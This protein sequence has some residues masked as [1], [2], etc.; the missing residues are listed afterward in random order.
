[1]TKPGPNTQKDERWIDAL[2]R[3]QGGRV[4]SFVC[5]MVGNR[6]VAED[7]TQETFLRAFAAAGGFEERAL[8]GT[9]LLTI[10]RNLA[11]NHL[12]KKARTT[13][14]GDWDFDAS[15]SPAAGPAEAAQAGESGRLIRTAVAAL[16]PAHR[17]VFLLKVVEGLTYR[18]IAAI[19]GCPVG[20]VQS[21]L[22]YAVRKL[23]QR[24]RAQGVWR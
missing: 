23:R 9:W 11:I 2:Y 4:Y 10:A 6:H 14:A 16:G 13:A 15:P 18:E 19:T 8:P 21:R 12:K 24:L 22:Y 7:L 5:A 1:M 17:E 20:T 3:E